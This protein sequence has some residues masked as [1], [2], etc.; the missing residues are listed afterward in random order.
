MCLSLCLCARMCLSVCLGVPLYVSV[1]DRLGLSLS[2]SLSVCLC[3][4]VCA[5]STCV[6]V[7]VQA[8]VYPMAGK[9]VSTWFVHG[10]GFAMGGVLGAV[11]VG[12]VRYI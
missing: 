1:C 10:R 8:L 3:A 7:L 4:C 6:C 12:S 2:L 5:W 9:V 11:T